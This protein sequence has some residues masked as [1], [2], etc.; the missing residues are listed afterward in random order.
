MAGQIRNTQTWIKPV[1]FNWLQFKSSSLVL[2]CMTLHHFIAMK[3]II[4]KPDSTFLWGFGRAIPFLGVKNMSCDLVLYVVGQVSTQTSILLK[5]G[6]RA[7]RPLPGLLIC[8]HLPKWLC[9][10]VTV[11][12]TNSTLLPF[13]L[14][15]KFRQEKDF[16]R[17]GFRDCEESGVGNIRTVLPRHWVKDTRNDLRGI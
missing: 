8:S 1:S 16:G 2:S 5:K 6:C 4:K 15:G 17:S 3:R 9:V 13:D 11:W 7:I 12:Q 10:Q 14:I